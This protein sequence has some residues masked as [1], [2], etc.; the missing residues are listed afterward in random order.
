VIHHLYLHFRDALH[1]RSG[2][3]DDFLWPS[4]RASSRSHLLDDLLDIF[5][6]VLGGFDTPSRHRVEGRI[7]GFAS[8]IRKASSHHR[9]EIAW[10]HLVGLILH[11]YD[12]SVIM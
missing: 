5:L 1:L 11:G 12:S 7:D 6:A 4:Q 2:G 10:R 3:L 8:L 9:I